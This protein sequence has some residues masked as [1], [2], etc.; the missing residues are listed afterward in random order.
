PHHPDRARRLSNLGAA[1]QARFAWTGQLTNL[2]EAIS[3][4]RAAVAVTPPDH[5]DR[6]GYL[7]NLGAALQARFAWTGQLTNL[8][9]AI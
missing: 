9:E 4:G 8:D 2:D 5:P 1:L 7:S 3:V 6:A